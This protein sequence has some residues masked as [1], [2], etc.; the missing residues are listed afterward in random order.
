MLRFMKNKI[1]IPLLIAGA[2]AC[3]FSFS[4]G[5]DEGGDQRRTIVLETVM[6]AIKEGHFAPREVDDS[7]SSSIYHKILDNLDYEK[8]FFTQQDI[9]QL[10][11]Y[12]YKLDDQLQDGSLEFFNKLDELFTK[13]LENS[14]TIYKEILAKPFSFTGNDEIQLD[15]EKLGYA[16]NETALKERWTKILKYRAL[17]KYVELKDDQKKKQEDKD[18]TAKVEIKTDAQLEKEAR[19]SIRKNYDYY[20]KRLAK[21]DD[22]QR[23][24]LFVNA[25]TSSEDPHT[26]YMPPVDKAKFDEAMSGTFYGIGAQ[27]R[28]DEGKIKVMEIL[29]GTPCWKQGELKAGDEILKVAQGSETPKDIQ[30]YD[31]EDAV[32]LIRGPKGTEVRLTV[33]KVDGSQKVIPIIRGEIEKAEVFAKS[34]IIKSKEGNVGYI[35]LP[36]F[37]FDAQRINGRRCAED[38]AVEIQKLKTEGVSGIIID[39]RNNGG[40]SLS[41]VVDMTGLF[42][43]QGPIVQVKSS[44]SSPV[45]L[46]DRVKGTLYDGPLAI[47]VGQ[48]SASASE[49]MAAALQDYKRAIIVGTPTFGKGTVQ[50]LISLDDFVDPV[51]RMRMKADDEEAIGSIKL[52][53]QKFYRINGGST[54]LK[55]VTPDIVFPDP[56][57]Y[58]DMGERSDKAALKWDEIPAASYKPVSDPVNVTAL[59]EASKKRVANNANFELIEKS[60][61]RLKAKK[62]DQVFPLNEAAYRKE[63]AES[64]TLSKQ[65]EEV[66]KKN[67]PLAL[68]NPKADMPTINMDSVNITK[69]ETW[70]KS[71][72][73]DLYLA[74]TV[75]IINDM[76][77]PAVKLEHEMGMK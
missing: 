13:R 42:V 41:D 64:E 27:L 26:D 2:L 19:E 36:E 43:D 74:E 71:L 22:K 63:L 34:A 62:D 37:Y 50:K 51:N 20:F 18:A 32:K 33:K 56:Y 67:T 8:K 54:Q 46:T 53:V 39:L 16:S 77:K 29:P 17:I 11:K 47:M 7:L 44:Y 75:N 1:L 35:Y 14:D 28:E 9:N 31:I 72:S 59:R 70:L 52:T 48:G 3:F 5:N 21:L 60:A 23:F 61:Q 55:G 4:Y 38:V 12:E 58:I 45:T 73:K 66:E 15:Y 68:V 30:G 76:H 57:A 40:G 10:S 69:N 65:I 25:I 24:T 49:I 6:K